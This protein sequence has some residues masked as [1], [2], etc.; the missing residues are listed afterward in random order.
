MFPRAETIPEPNAKRIPRRLLGA[1]AG[2]FVQNSANMMGKTPSVDIAWLWKPEIRCVFSFSCSR[3]AQIPHD[4]SVSTI[5]KSQRG[6]ALLREKTIAVHGPPLRSH[7]HR[8][9][10]RAL[11]IDSPPSF[12]R[13]AR[14]HHD[15]D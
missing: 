2:S 11:E 14:P 9:L 7:D 4:T 8:P 3:I 6:I 13:L 5:Q 10:E 1:G 15:V 12:L